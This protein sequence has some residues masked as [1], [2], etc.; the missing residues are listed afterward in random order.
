M[1]RESFDKEVQLLRLLSEDKVKSKDFDMDN[2][3][4]VLRPFYKGGE[5]DFLLNAREQLDLLQQRFI[6][7]ELD[8]I[9]GAHEMVA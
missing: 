2:F 9:K 1:A 6:V 4:Y 5:Y 8:T 7:F 3:L